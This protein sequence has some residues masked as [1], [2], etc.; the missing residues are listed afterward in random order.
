MLARR[1]L[2]LTGVDHYEVTMRTQSSVIPSCK[3][4]GVGSNG[5]CREGFKSQTATN[6]L[7]GLLMRCRQLLAEPRQS[8]NDTRTTP[9]GAL[10]ATARIAT[11]P[12]TKT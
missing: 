7:T 1:R 6:T 5:Q 12:T 10:E 3:T 11:G 2:R 9:A 4:V 8:G